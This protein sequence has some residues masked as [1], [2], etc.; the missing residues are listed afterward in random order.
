MFGFVENN[1]II[2]SIHPLSASAEQVSGSSQEG[3]AVSN[4]ILEQMQGFAAAVEEMTG[5][6][7]QLSDSVIQEEE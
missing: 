7:E 6:V 4:V 3:M 2:D 1:H 5:M